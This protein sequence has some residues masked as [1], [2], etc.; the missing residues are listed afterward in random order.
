M[1]CLLPVV[2]Q[3]LEDSPAS[4]ICES[5]EDNF[6]GSWHSETITVWL[7][8]VKQESDDFEK[9]IGDDVITDG[10]WRVTVCDLPSPE[11][12]GEESIRD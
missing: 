8:F 4:G 2:G 12:R 9:R 7:W 10:A 5:F 6:D 1:N 3:S 11:T